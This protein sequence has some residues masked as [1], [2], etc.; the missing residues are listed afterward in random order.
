MSTS[1]KNVSK[2]VKVL[3]HDDVKE[4]NN[5]KNKI[6]KHTSLQHDIFHKEIFNKLN[7]GCVLSFIRNE[8]RKESVKS[9]L[10]EPAKDLNYDLCMINKYEEYL[11]HSLSF[12]SE[13]D[14]EDDENEKGNSFDSLNDDKSVEQIEIFSK[15]GRKCSFDKDDEELKI[16]L[17]KDWNDIK[18]LLLKSEK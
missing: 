17:E 6:K 14:L 1:P 10:S 13:F 7:E 8:K 9:S 11:N 12:I 18:D 16:K 3:S 4:K 15:N 5:M 2:F